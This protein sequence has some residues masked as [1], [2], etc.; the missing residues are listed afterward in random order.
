MLNVD[1]KLCSCDCLLCVSIWYN[2]KKDDIVVY[3]YMDMR[4]KFVQQL[5]T[6]C[7]WYMCCV[8]RV[9]IIVMGK[10]WN[11]LCWKAE[12]VKNF[13]TS[14]IGKRYFI[15]METINVLQIIQISHT[16]YNIY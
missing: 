10:K 7:V 5:I 15:L 3:V 16:L 9:K 12:V 4:D 13:V 2:S 14:E 6:C 1:K 8:Y 11:Y